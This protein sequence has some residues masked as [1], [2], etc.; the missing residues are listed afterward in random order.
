MAQSDNIMQHVPEYDR[1]AVAVWF[2][3]IFRD[4]LLVFGNLAF[5]PRAWGCDICLTLVAG[6]AFFFVRACVS[7]CVCLNRNKGSTISERSNDYLLI[8]ETHRG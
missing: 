2:S 5:P 6:L 1:I 3:M 4:W 8:Q 7:L